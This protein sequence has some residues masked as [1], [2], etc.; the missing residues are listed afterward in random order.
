MWEKYKQAADDIQVFGTLLTDLSKASDEFLTAKSNIY[1][2]SLKAFKPVP[3]ESKNKNNKSYSWWKADSLW[4][5]SRLG[6]WT[7]FVQQ[8]MI[9]TLLYLY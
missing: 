3:G 1:R 7:C 8:R 9:S 2:F 6:V 5:A 4:S